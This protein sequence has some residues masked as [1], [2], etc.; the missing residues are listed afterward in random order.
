[1]MTYGLALGSLLAG[2]LLKKFLASTDRPLRAINTYI[3]WLALP[4]VIFSTLPDM[5]FST[6]LL[7]PLLTPWLLIALSFLVIYPLASRLHWSVE[8]KIAV[9]LMIGLGNTAFF[10]VPLVKLLLGAGAV[11]A[12]I[13]YDQ[14]G[15]F[16]IL[17]VVA[18]A[19]VA[20]YSGDGKRP[21]VKSILW[22]V[23]RFPPFISLL[24][25]LLLPSTEALAGMLPLLSLLGNTILPLAMLMVGLQFSIQVEPAYKWPVFTVIAG[26]LLVT[27]LIVIAVGMFFTSNP[28]VFNATLIQS[29]MPPMV[30]PA[31]L[32]IGAGLAPRFVATTLGLATLCAFVTVPL[33]IMHWGFF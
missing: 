30:T 3:I 1:M 2:I 17:S 31:I 18:T 9:T 27:P 22:K 23:V 12:A 24:L 10:G 19:A 20:V 5:Q 21:S 14:L 4:A 26:K 13:I 28:Q 15:S 7:L 32:L 8:I 25:A 16:I 33:W 29:A 6:K 11:P